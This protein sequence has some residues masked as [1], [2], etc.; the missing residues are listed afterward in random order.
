MSRERE[1][2]VGSQAMTFCKEPGL[3]EIY[4]RKKL[5]LELVGHAVIRLGGIGEVFIVLPLTQR[6]VLDVIQRR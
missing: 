2:Q 4:E 5:E 1:A 3:P 6:Q